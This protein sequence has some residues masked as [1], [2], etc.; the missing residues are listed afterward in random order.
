MNRCEILAARILRLRAVE[1]NPRRCRG[2]QP[3]PVNEPV[4][5][6]WRCYGHTLGAQLLVWNIAVA[7]I[8]HDNRWALARYRSLQELLR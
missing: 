7:L 1:P 3:F 8:R 4:A 2:R 5:V 6:V